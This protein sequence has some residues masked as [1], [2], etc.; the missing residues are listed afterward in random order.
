MSE[1]IFVR[2]GQASFGAHAYDKL[3]NR[4]VEQVKM[5]ARHWQSLGEKFDYIYSGT[6]QRQKETANEFLSLM[7]GETFNAVEHT[8]FNEY[9]ADSLMQVFL[10]DHAVEAGFDVSIPWPVEDAALF[11]QMFE[12]ATS[13][14]IRD[15]LQPA[16]DDMSFENWSAFQQRVHGALDEIMAKHTGGSRVL[17]STSGGVIATALQRVLQIPDDK[18]I[19]TNWMVQNSSVTRIKYGNGRI[20]LTQF[21]SLA[22]LEKAGLH[23]MVTYR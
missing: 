17:I 15:E 3:S 16:A 13:K 4:G 8:G 7:K 11:Q 22:H 10:R 21:N 9:S 6:L 23:H 2:H 20:S 19:A 1:L 18:V 5:L 12:A 14:W